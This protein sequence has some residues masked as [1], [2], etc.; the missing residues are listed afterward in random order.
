V[1]GNTSA[2]KDSGS[3]FTVDNTA[4]SV[5]ITGPFTASGGTTSLTAV[6]KG[7]TGYYTVAFGESSATLDA[8][9]VEANLSATG[10]GATVGTITATDSGDGLKWYVAVPIDG[11]SAD[12]TVG[13]RV[14][15]GAVQDA[16]GNLSA[17]KDSTASFIV[18]TTPPS[19]NGTDTPTYSATTLTLK[20]SADGSGVT[21]IKW[22]TV[23]SGPYGNT[24]TGLLAPG[25]GAS[26]TVTATISPHQTVTFYYVML[27]AAGNQSEEKA[28]TTS[29]GG[30]TF[31]GTKSIQAGSASTKVQVKSS[32]VS[33]GSDPYAAFSSFYGKSTQASSVEEARVLAQNASLS[34]TRAAARLPTR[35]ASPTAPVAAQ[36]SAQPAAPAQAVVYRPESG[37]TRSAAPIEPAKTDEDPRPAKAGAKPT[38]EAPATMVSFSSSAQPAGGSQGQQLPSPQP[39]DGQGRMP[40]ALLAPSTW[41]EEEP[42]RDES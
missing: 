28:M 40:P 31:T 5:T 30:S 38:E 20:I 3:T 42:G 25:A 13:L 19:Q 21:A 26:G 9:A 36:P 8:A 41:R 7:G 14:A 16:V 22:G 11:A 17:I 35:P 24:A 23:S 33:Y 18:D 37:A 27:D 12:G 39:Q 1:A 10:S 4:P 15:A 29:D 32:E 2:L 34:R 6:Q